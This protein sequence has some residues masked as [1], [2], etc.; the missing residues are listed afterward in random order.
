VFAIYLKSTSLDAVP[1]SQQPNFGLLKRAEDFG[2]PVYDVCHR[3]V[4]RQKQGTFVEEVYVLVC[5]DGKEQ[6]ARVGCHCLDRSF[7]RDID[8]YDM[9]IN[10]MK[11]P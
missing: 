8:G 3:L 1:F 10:I 11:E 7:V 5:L 4:V 2:V 9:A 6:S